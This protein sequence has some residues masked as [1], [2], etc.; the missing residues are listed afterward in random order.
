[1]N[2]KK[3]IKRINK[4]SISLSVIGFIVGLVVT[5]LYFQPK[6]AYQEKIANENQTQA[7]QNHNEAVSYKER[8]ASVSAEIKTLQ[9]KPPQVEYRTQ[10]QFVPAPD[11]SVEDKQNSPPSMQ[12]YPCSLSYPGATCINGF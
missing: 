4:V 8:L 2:I 12:P 11:H 6:I 5:Y 10:T 9:N 3:Y 1:M 7:D